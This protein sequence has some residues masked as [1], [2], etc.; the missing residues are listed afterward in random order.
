M[1]EI[2]ESATHTDMLTF[3]SVI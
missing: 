3:I 1:A 2:P